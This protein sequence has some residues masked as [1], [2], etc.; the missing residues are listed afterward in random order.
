MDTRPDGD[1]ENAILDALTSQ[2]RRGEIS[3][4]VRL[5]PDGKTGQ[6]RPGCRILGAPPTAAAHALRLSLYEQSTG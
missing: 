3:R 5:E 1:A 6:R 4:I 2:Q